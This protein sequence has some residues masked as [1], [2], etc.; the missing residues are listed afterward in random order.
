MEILDCG[1]SS[2]NNF[3]LFLLTLS[4]LLNLLEVQFT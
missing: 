1:N 4:M 2:V 3:L